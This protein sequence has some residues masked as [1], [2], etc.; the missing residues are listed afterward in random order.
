M[1][2]TTTFTTPTTAD[3]A[4]RIGVSICIPRVFNNINHRRIKNW[5][6]QNLRGWGFV[7]RVDVV[8]VFKDG[9][10]VHKRAYVHYAV[11]KFNL[12]ADDGSGNKI[13]DALVGGDTIQVVYDD[14]WY[15]K[16][17]LSR[18][19]RPAEPPKPR[20]GPT[21]KIQLKSESVYAT[22]RVLRDIDE[23]HPVPDSVNAQ[24]AAALAAKGVEGSDGM[25]EAE[26]ASIER[27]PTMTRSPIGSEVCRDISCDEEKYPDAN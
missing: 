10:Q 3:E 19:A 5:F 12:N 7:E 17:S 13:I 27:A 16:L 23:L 20:Q 8:P 18:A 2:T 15:W 22:G 6:I 26:I 25:T 9:R 14:P 24:G 21:V 11:G 1:S 4:N